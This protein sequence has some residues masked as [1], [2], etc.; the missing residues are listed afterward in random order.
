M[1]I[2]KARIASD[3]LLSEI[4]KA[5]SV[6]EAE[7]AAQD[8][9]KFTDET[10]EQ[11]YKSYQ[12]K[13]DN[14]KPPKTVREGESVRIV[15]LNNKAT[16]LKTP[17]KDGQ[18]YV[19]AGIMKLYVPISDLRIIKDTGKD[20]LVDKPKRAFNTLATSVFVSNSFKLKM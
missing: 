3:K 19:Q 16:V 17:D 10:D 5:S 14:T 20:V 8:F 12:Q 11:L 18:V 4:R 9:R 6:K 15:S 7:K 2:N 1:I 13:I